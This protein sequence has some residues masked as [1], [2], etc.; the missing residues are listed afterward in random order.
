[1]IAPYNIENNGEVNGGGDDDSN[2]SKNSGDYLCVADETGT[3][4]V[5]VIPDHLRGQTNDDM[6]HGHYYLEIFWALKE[7][8]LL[9][10][11]QYDI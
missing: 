5:M 1:M 10:L 6:V 4:H 8:I 3:V 9:R 11:V 7:L 2:G